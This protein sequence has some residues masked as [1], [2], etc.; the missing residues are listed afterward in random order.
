MKDFTKRNYIKVWSNMAP[1]KI[2]QQIVQGFEINAPHWHQYSVTTKLQ[3]NPQQNYSDIVQ[4][5]E[6][7]S[8]SIVI[9][10]SSNSVH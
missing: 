1:V 9:M 7:Q 6:R 4:S 3:T 10:L 8:V 5:F 2:K